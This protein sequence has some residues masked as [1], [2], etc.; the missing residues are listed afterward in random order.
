MEIGEGGADDV[1]SFDLDASYDVGNGL[2]VLAG[3]FGS[4]VDGDEMGFYAAATY[5]LGGGAELLFSYATD[6]EDDVRG[7]DLGDPEYKEGITV[8]ASFS[9]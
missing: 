9:F 3:A 4:D 2:T 1:G 5:D 8:E 7:E 6:G